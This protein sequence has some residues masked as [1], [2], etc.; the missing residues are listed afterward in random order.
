MIDVIINPTAGSGY[1]KRIGKDICSYM[2][3]KCIEHRV[4]FTEYPGHARELAHTAAQNKREIVICVGG[5]GTAFEVAGGLADSDTAMGLIPAGTGNDFCK[6]IQTQKSPIDALKEILSSTP[7]RLDLG[8]A[9]E[10][11]FLNICGTG[12]DTQVLHYSER[13]K[14]YVRGMTPYIFGILLAIFKHKPYQLRIT[15][16]DSLVLEGNFLLC[17]V[18][19]GRYFGGGIPVAPYAEVDDA[20]LDVILV[21]HVNKLRIPFYLLGLLNKKILRYKI[22]KFFRAKKIKLE[23]MN[24]KQL[25][26]NEDGEIFRAKEVTFSVRP[27]SLKMYW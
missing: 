7:R 2:N 1:A 8:N 3:D 24:G 5:D 15:I 21:D 20:Y 11:I 6:S 22:S 25:V 18:A 9:G 10:N 23:S 16:D 27:K 13:V 26:L 4:Y 19:N 12:I 14:K 17:S